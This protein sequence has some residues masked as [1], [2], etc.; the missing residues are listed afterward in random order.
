[1]KKTAGR[2]RLGLHWIWWSGT[3][4]LVFLSLILAEISILSSLQSRGLDQAQKAL[5]SEASLARLLLEDPLST[6]DRS[7]IETLVARVGREI[8]S[9]LTVIGVDGT[10]IADSDPTHPLAESTQPPLSHPEVQEAIERGEGSSV[11]Y[12]ERLK[13]RIL[14]L[15]VPVSAE[16]RSI[17]FLRLTMPLSDMATQTERLRRFL[18]TIFLV[19]VTLSLPF[20]FLI[21]KKVNE[22]LEKMRRA[23]ARIVPGNLSPQIQPSHGDDLEEFGVLLDRISEEISHQLKELSEDRAKLSAILNGMIEGVMVLDRQGRVL[24]VNPALERMFALTVPIPMDK[25]HYELIRHRELN[26]F[27]EGVLSQR[28][29]LVIEIGL[30]A[31]GEHFF[32][33]QASLVAAS[34][35]A[36]PAYAILVFHDVTELRRLERVRKDFVANVSHELKT[37]LTS[38]K[39]Y[40][41]AVLDLDPEHQE[42]SRE[43]L[44]IVQ[45]HSQR[46][47]HMLSDLL[48]LARIESGRDRV[49]PQRL[50]LKSFL[51]KIVQSLATQ[52]EKKRQ[53]VEIE[54]DDEITFDVD[55][56]KLSQ[57]LTN[58]LDNA[59]KY[60][61]S[62]GRIVL[63]ARR[64]EAG[65][66]LLVRDNGIG[67]PPADLERIFERF[68]RV[69]RARSRELGGTGLGLSIVK[70]IVEAHGGR[71]T[72]ESQPGAGSTF[73]AW[74]PTHR[75]DP[76]SPHEPIAPAL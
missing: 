2:G 5:R 42:Q 25:Y 74:F 65:V 18:L 68:Y 52:A 45:K 70:H 7:G 60:T 69:D 50:L 4:L 17:G 76:Y 32:Q 20:V 13:E 37:P 31:Q 66:E 24:L 39:G 9:H 27:I 34:A 75:A 16:G 38:I 48:Q 36:Y 3:I 35:I 73:K 23:A 64:T 44:F 6:K 33:V 57:V 26:D 51:E 14:S 21:W 46:M 41:E 67:I 19:V 58:L 71:V 29:N 43:F 40:V 8:Q 72:V 49:V 11:E 54:V 15:A 59:I 22:P 10:I 53:R 61:P 63:G 47:E 12:S 1:M 55:P 62:G 30:S 56:E 28:Q